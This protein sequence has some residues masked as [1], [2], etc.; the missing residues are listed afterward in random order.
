MAHVI[1]ADEI[2]KS[3]KLKY[4]HAVYPDGARKIKFGHAIDADGNGGK[5]A[6][7]FYSA[8]AFGGYTGE[9]T[10]SQ[11]TG[12]DGMLYKLYTLT[13]SG[14]LT[15]ND[16][17]EYWICGGGGKGYAQTGSNG[18]A[19]G[20]G[21]GGGYVN[22]GELS[23]GEY[24]VIIGSAA[25]NSSIGDAIVADRGKN[26]TGTTGADGGSGGGASGYTA[27]AGSGG[28]GAGV[29]TYPFGITSLYAHCAGG[30]GGS[31]IGET[32]SG[33]YWGVSG[34]A[35]ASNGGT[36]SKSTKVT[37]E[38]AVASYTSFKAGSG[39]NRGGG[40]G[41]TATTGNAGSATFYGSGGGGAGSGVVAGTE[42]WGTAGKGYQGVAYI[43]VPA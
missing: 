43:L 34:T 31:R 17:A 19:G 23:A 39:G 33:T 16:S 8:S 40:K 11:V 1:A 30:G 26:S 18:N 15:L 37:E 6:R 27:I 29:S 20:G 12:A 9:F 32:T 38:N 28:K 14:T 35:G 13:K 24:A 2:K 21:G 41:G 10:V 36:A 42:Y 7:K 25:G 3:L 5:L 4:G 22:S